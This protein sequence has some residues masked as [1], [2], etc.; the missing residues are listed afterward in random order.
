MREWVVELEAYGGCVDSLWFFW[1]RLL[2]LVGEISETED[3]G[4]SLY[5][6]MKL[7]YE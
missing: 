3:F 2:L 7:L 5:Q 6:P 1:L 4:V